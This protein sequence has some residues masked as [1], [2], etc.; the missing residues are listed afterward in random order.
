[1]ATML[2]YAQISRDVYESESDTSIP[3]WSRLFTFDNDHVTGFYGAVYQAEDTREIVVAFRGTWDFSGDVDADVAIVTSK[4]PE[5][6]YDHALSLY[7]FALN[8]Y[9]KPNDF[10]MSLTGHSL[11]GALTSLVSAT[12]GVPGVA[13]NAPGVKEIVTSLPKAGDPDACDVLNLNA[14]HDPVSAVGEQIGKIVNIDVDQSWLD[15]IIR[16]LSPVVYRYQQHKMKRLV[17]AVSAHQL[18]DDPP[19]AWLVR[20]HEATGVH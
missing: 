12:T 16:Y 19:T 7:Q 2:S 18:R 6:Q 14:A 20:H 13:F 3:G 1:M 5:K 15:W 17:A 4:L 8:K 10:D 11:G 9:V